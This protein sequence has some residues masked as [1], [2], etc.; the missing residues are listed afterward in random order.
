M[1]LRFISVLYTSRY[2]ADGT[3]VAGIKLTSYDPGRSGVIGNYYP[4]LQLVPSSHRLNP[5][6]KS[7]PFPSHSP[8]VFAG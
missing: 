7:L 2:E 3:H 5:S 1:H 8:S 4:A 6:G